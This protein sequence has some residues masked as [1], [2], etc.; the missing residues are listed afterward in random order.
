MVKEAL[1]TVAAKLWKRRLLR[2]AK[3]LKP[4][5]RIVFSSRKGPLVVK[6]AEQGA[7]F[8]DVIKPSGLWYS[9]GDEW[10]KWCLSEMP[11]WIDTWKTVRRIQVRESKILKITNEREFLRFETNRPVKLPPWML[12]IRKLRAVRQS[13]EG[14][15]KARNV[16]TDWGKI[17]EKYA[18]IEITPYLWKFRLTHL[19]Y[20]GWDVA[21]GTIWDPS[22][23]I[24]TE[25]LLVR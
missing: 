6:P 16:Y 7:S 14:D 5:E 15:R 9:F 23:I 8:D 3:K 20:Y 25:T 17:A 24:G 18:G 13:L 1:K 12:E 10:L 11:E 4:T 22:A 19:W 21:S 2:L